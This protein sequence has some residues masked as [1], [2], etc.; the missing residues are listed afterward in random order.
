MSNQNEHLWDGDGDDAGD[1]FD[2]KYEEWEQRDWMTWLAANL[3][4]P[5]KV[6]REEDMDDAD[7]QQ[8]TPGSLF[9]VGHTMEIV[10]LDGEDEL[11]G[12]V[13][14]AKEKGQI[15]HLPLADLE[16]KPKTD[17]NYWPVREYVVWFANR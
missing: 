16:V 9:Q 6:S 17:D 2:V 4:F 7:S 12:I 10:G 8:G 15:G 13:V 11:M 5:F 14:E 1:A 3:V